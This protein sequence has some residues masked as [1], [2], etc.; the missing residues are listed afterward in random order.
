MRWIT[1]GTL[2]VV[3]LVLSASGT[4]A[5]HKPLHGKIIALDAGHGG[6]EV[7]AQYPAIS[8]TAAE[9]FEK[10]LNL[11]VVY[12]LKAKLEVEGGAQVVLTRVVDETI[13]SRRARVGIAIEKCKALA[14]R[15]CDA[16]VSVHHN[17]STD[18]AYDGLL[19]IYNEKQDLPLATAV[20]DALRLGLCYPD[21]SLTTACTSTY[22]YRFVDEG[23]RNGG[24]G[25]TVFGNLVS[26]LT[27]AYYI[28]NDWEAAQYRSG[29]PTNICDSSGNCRQVLQGART[30]AEATATYT[31]LVNYFSRR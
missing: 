23:L 9:F 12:A 31:G 4:A 16:L 29:T 2:L 26:I 15:K 10:D 14:G 1:A 8:G 5:D 21:P 20:H 7:G 17:G 3:L 27:E 25:M 6:T 13:S 11:A 19:V 30:G 22:K 28:T 24:Y 18:P